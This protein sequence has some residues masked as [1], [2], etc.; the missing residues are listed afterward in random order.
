MQF[1]LLGP[2]EVVTDAGAVDVGAGKRH[3]LLAH[4]IIHAN[5]V[6]SAERLIDELW[7]EHPPVTAAKN[8]HV[9]VSQ[10]RKATTY[11]P[12]VVSNLRRPR[13][14][15]LTTSSIPPP[16]PI[17][18]SRLSTPAKGSVDGAAPTASPVTVS[19][20]VA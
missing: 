16:S 5:E 7:D 17:T 13:R 2:L 19:V 20:G 18:P 1:R 12:S 14:W 10:L 15:L 6:V 8:V 4:L 11:T 9:Y 3:A